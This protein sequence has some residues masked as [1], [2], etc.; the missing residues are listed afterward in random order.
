M[1]G[2]DL[3]HDREVQSAIDKAQ[4]P[5]VVKQAGSTSFWVEQFK[6]LDKALPRYD[7]STVTDWN[8]A[9]KHYRASGLRGRDA[10]RPAHWY[11]EYRTGNMTLTDAAAA[12]SRELPN[13]ERVLGRPF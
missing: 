1:A 6:A 10:G 2:S 5:H 13:A 9:M 8:K 12:A 4:H 11:Q 3:S 7:S